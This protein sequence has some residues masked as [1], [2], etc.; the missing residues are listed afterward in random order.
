MTPMQIA[1]LAAVVLVASFFVTGAAR[2]LALRFHVIDVPNERSSHTVPTPRIGGVGIVVSFFT[3]LVLVF[4]YGQGIPPDLKRRLIGLAIG[5]ALIALI[6][7]VEDIYSASSKDRYGISVAFRYAGQVL[8]AMIAVYYGNKVTA[9]SLPHWTIEF[10]LESIVTVLWVTWMA[11]AYNFMDGIDGLAGGIGV[12]YA[13]FSAIVA[14]LTGQEV[15]AIVCLILAASCLGFLQHNFP[16]AKVFM[17]DVGAIFLGYVFATVSIMLS[18]EQPRLTSLTPL[19]IIYATVNYDAAYTLLRRIWREKKMF[20]PHRTHL[21]QRLIIRGLSHKQ[22][23]LIYYSISVG[24]G[25]LALW[26]VQTSILGRNGILLTVLLILLAGTLGVATYE[27]HLNRT[28]MIDYGE[29]EKIKVAHISPFDIQ[30][31]LILNHLKSLRDDGFE[32]HIVCNEG[33]LLPMFRQEGFHIHVIET[34]RKIAPL[35]DLRLL[36]DLFLLMRRERFSIVHTHT[37]K[38]ELI[39][40][41]AAK[42]ARVP[43]VIYTNHGFF[44]RRE[45]SSWRRR[46]LINMARLA[47]HF[48]DHVLS[49]SKG[50]IDTALE[51]KMYRSDQISYLGNGVNLEQYDVKRFTAETVRDKKLEIGI[52][53]E[54][55]VIGIVGRY[56]LEKGYR[57][58]FEAAK[59]ISESYRD[60]FFLTVGTTVPGERDPVDPDLPRQLRIADRVV[61]LES[62]LDMP[63]LYSVMDILVSPTYREGF[64]RSLIEGS[65]M[66]RPI[67]S[68]DILGCRE[69]VINGFNGYLVPMK[70]V[71]PLTEKIALLLDNPELREQIG[72]HGRELAEREFDENK[73]IARLKRCYKEKLSQRFL[74]LI[75]EVA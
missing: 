60:V 47:G 13:L 50:D 1:L 59:Q 40:Q 19:L 27:Q 57:E 36:K 75:K 38:I 24:L 45:M 53:P 33:R 63:D 10:W 15:M 30:I 72:R 3:G 54:S 65:A 61:R 71:A 37:P 43:V 18:A 29:K 58:F 73:V 41:M 17:G 44:F 67:V 49:Q 56:V 28:S 55:R 11:N 8:A 23:T 66:S 16:R 35:V 22:V 9:L 62:R 64:P 25:G 51:E 32:V 2:K 34:P 42:L 4:L 69:A 52:S 12:I 70:K 5:A 14:L 68:T 20:S 21:Y 48:S 26:Y 46:F 7:F 39:G 74:P 31:L 6:S